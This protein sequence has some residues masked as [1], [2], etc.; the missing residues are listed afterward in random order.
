MHCTDSQLESEFFGSFCSLSV[1]RL[2]CVQAMA[3]VAVKPSLPF[4]YKRRNRQSVFMP[5]WFIQKPM[6]MVTR[7][8]VIFFAIFCDNIY[9]LQKLGDVRR[10]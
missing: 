8:K 6:Q 2:S 4:I 7:T 1:V 5:L 3:I 10:K 9:F